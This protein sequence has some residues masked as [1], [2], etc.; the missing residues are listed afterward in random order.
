MCFFFL[1]RSP[2]GEYHQ[3]TYLQLD[4]FCLPHFSPLACVTAAR[5]NYVLCEK[6]K[7]WRG[8]NNFWQFPSRGRDSLGDPLEIIP[9]SPII[10]SSRCLLSFPPTHK[11]P[12]LQLTRW[13]YYYTAPKCCSEPLFEKPFHFSLLSGTCSNELLSLHKVSAVIPILHKKRWPSASSDSGCNYERPNALLNCAARLLLARQSPVLCCIQFSLFNTLRIEFKIGHHCRS[14]GRSGIP[15][16]LLNQK[17]NRTHT[18]AQYHL[19]KCL[20]Q[21]LAR[22]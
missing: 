1:I 4:L 16:W 10:P 5:A 22:L 7:K 11:L 13:V 3:V 17:E 6:K 14:E 12:L 18:D 8:R 2:E 21:P 15:Y 20:I 9:C 19:G